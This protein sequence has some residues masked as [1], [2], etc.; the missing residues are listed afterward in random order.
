M[1]FKGNLYDDSMEL[2][3]D[4]DLLL[5]RSAKE[6]K[7][8]N[9]YF[10]DVSM[11]I[12]DSL[13]QKIK[14]IPYW[15]FIKNDEKNRLK[16]RLDSF[17]EKYWKASALSTELYVF[18]KCIDETFIEIKDFKNKSGIILFMHSADGQIS[19]YEDLINT[20]DKI[21]KENPEFRNRV[22]KTASVRSGM[23]LGEIIDARPNITEIKLNLADIMN[24]SV[25]KSPLCFNN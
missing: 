11:L 19:A 3:E 13:W 10:A 8:L 25:S 7:E 12:I 15:N 16:W 9:P 17:S 24:Y 20:A 14:K 1:A 2:K 22:L 4:I 18:S 5:E 23:T 21:I 6:L